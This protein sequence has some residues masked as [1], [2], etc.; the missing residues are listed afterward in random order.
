M[1][2][3]ELPLP[4][5]WRMH[6]SSPQSTHRSKIYFVQKE[7]YYDSSAA[8]RQKTDSELADDLLKFID[9]NKE[10]VVVVD[11]SAT[12]FIVEL[13][14][15]G[16]YV[17]K[18]NNSVLDGIRHVSQLLTA[19]R[20]GLNSGSCTNLI[21]EFY[22]Y[23]W[24]PNAQRRGEDKPLKQNDHVL[25]ALRYVLMYMETR[26]GTSIIECV[27]SAGRSNYDRTDSDSRYDREAGEDW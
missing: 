3:Q 9:G 20:L 11:P 26:E 18:A 1:Q 15:R 16:V 27:P 22:S 19:D 2:R 13:G 12:S 21:K 10:I 5:Y 14:R 24:D 8:G 4:L 7:F 25:D 6:R 23:V 17:V